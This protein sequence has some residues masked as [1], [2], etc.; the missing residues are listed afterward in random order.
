VDA[1]YLAC[2]LAELEAAACARGLATPPAL[3]AL[4]LDVALQQGSQHPVRTLPYCGNVL[5]LKIYVLPTERSL[6][7]M[8]SICKELNMSCGPRP[9]IS[10]ALACFGKCSHAG[11]N[12]HARIQQ[13]PAAAW[14]QVL[15]RALMQPGSATAEVAARLEAS[16]RAG[17]LAQGEGAAAAVRARLG[18]H[19]ERCRALLQQGHVVAS[20]R[21]ARAHRVESL[22][23]SAFLHAAAETGARPCLATRASC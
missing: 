6:Q 5:C 18:A 12:M 21:A 15:V 13:H 11:N 14:E 10:L 2:A 19:E 16:G 9:D 23:P 7:D 4:A 8:L 22:A 1:P 3:Q 20:L 17:E